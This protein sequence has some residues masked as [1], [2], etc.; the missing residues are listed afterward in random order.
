MFQCEPPT[1]LTLKAAAANA[2][3]SVLPALQTHGCQGSDDRSRGALLLRMPTTPMSGLR[4]WRFRAFTTS[5]KLERGSNCGYR[6][7]HT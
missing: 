2:R 6:V 1:P 3:G 7:P 5:K 4:D